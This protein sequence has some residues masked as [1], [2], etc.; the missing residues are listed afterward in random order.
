MLPPSMDYEVG[1]GRQYE[2]EQKGAR[3]RLVEEAL[4]G[5]PRQNPGFLARIVAFLTRARWVRRSQSLAGQNR[6]E[7]EQY[8]E[9]FVG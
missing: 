3:R 5:R 4:A 9:R 7:V 8:R 6:E 2:L 1:K